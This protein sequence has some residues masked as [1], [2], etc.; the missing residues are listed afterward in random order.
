MHVYFM[1]PVNRQHHLWT[2]SYAPGKIQYKIN[3]LMINNH[4]ENHSRVNGL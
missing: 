3:D 4:W 2:I 1:N